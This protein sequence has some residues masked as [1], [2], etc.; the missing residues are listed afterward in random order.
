LKLVAA[1]S[2]VS[3]MRNAA[4]G[5]AAIVA[6]LAIASVDAG[7]QRAFQSALFQSGYPRLIRV[8][9]TSGEVA[10]FSHAGVST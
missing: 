5:A 9:K 7:R 10:L 2:D 3:S 4:I 8:Q 1:T 6:A